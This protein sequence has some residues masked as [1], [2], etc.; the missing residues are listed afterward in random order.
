M[1][2]LDVQLAALER[3]DLALPDHQDERGMALFHALLDAERELERARL[4]QARAREALVK[5]VAA[6][7]EAQA[8]PPKR[9]HHSSF[10]AK[11]RKRFY[12]RLGE[13][14]DR[15]GFTKEYACDLAETVRLR[16]RPSAMSGNYH[17]AEYLAWLETPEGVEAYEQYALARLD[18]IAAK[19]ETRGPSV[20]CENCGK[21]SHPERCQSCGWQHKAAA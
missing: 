7:R 11:E 20:K 13:I 5:H 21:R 9:E 8:A 12:A 15:R 16:M 18:E 10:T 4:E 2:A 6:V 19:A 14:C 17:R 1:I 3:P